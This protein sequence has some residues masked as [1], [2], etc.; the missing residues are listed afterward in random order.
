MSETRRR[1]GTGAGGGAAAGA[2]GAAAS[3]GCAAAGAGGGAAAGAGGGAAAGAGG[4]AAGKT[5]GAGGA[6][7]AGPPPRPSAASG[8]AAAV[9]TAALRWPSG[10][11]PA[12]RAGAIALR[13]L[14]RAAVPL[15]APLRGTGASAEPVAAAHD[16]AAVAGEWVRPAAA[17]L[18]HPDAA[19][20]YFHGGAYVTSSPRTHRGIVARI[21]RA[22]GTP[23]FAARYRLAPEHRF[24]AAADDARAAHGW[25]RAQGIAPERI[26]VAGDSAGGHLAVGLALQLERE[27]ERRPA[28]LALLSPLLDPSFVLAHEEDRRVRD[29]FLTASAFAR[30]VGAHVDPWERDRRA[31]PLEADPAELAAL[32]PTLLQV[33]GREMLAAEARRFGERV[34]AA[35]G[36][37]TVQV[38]PGQIHVFQAQT[39]LLQEARAALADLGAFVAAAL[40]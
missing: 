4:A 37:C 6:V 3:A 9:A 39:A 17:D 23:V 26:V 20:L 19:I 14:F 7:L 29:P 15:V 25:L 1:A 10:A 2:G 31:T 21:A 16:G 22:T 33:G 38:W 27:D 12:N 5:T 13:G 24:P 40:S 18:R 36:D 28:A 35:G 32:P 11:I 8:R 30:L 34:R